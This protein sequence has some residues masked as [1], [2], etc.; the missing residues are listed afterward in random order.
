M[1]TLIKIVGYGLLAIMASDIAIYAL[2]NDAYVGAA[3]FG[4]MTL[5]WIDR[6]LAIAALPQTTAAKRP[7]STEETKMGRKVDLGTLTADETK[8]LAGECLAELSDEDAIDVIRDW[9]EANDTSD[10]LLAQLNDDD[11]ACT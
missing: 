8:E 7:R 4:L 2:K 11:T 10:E 6:L 5:V 9:A 3:L 1:S